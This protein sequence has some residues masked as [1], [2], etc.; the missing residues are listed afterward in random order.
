MD[1]WYHRASTRVSGVTSDLSAAKRF[2][3]AGHPLKDEARV[4]LPLTPD[5]Q[6]VEMLAVVRVVKARFGNGPRISGP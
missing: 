2:V 4:R 1:P 6:T 3:C 5:G